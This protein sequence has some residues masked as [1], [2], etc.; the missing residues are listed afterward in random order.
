MSVYKPKDR[1]FFL[2]D[3]QIKGSRFHGSTGAATRGEA[4]RVEELERRKARREIAGQPRQAPTITLDRAA[5]L[6]WS[7]VAKDQRSAKTTDYQLDRL[8]RMLGKST[9]L[10]DI[11]D[12]DI[13][14]YVRVR[15]GQK[16]RNGALPAPATINREIELLR[17]VLYRA[18]KVYKA[19]VPEIDWLAHKLVEPKGR[20]RT[21]SADE[22]R[23]L[24]DAAAP[25][26]RP[27][28]RFSLLTGVRLANAVDLD[29]KQI[30]LQA[31]VIEFR[32]KSNAPDGKPLVMPIGG[33]MLQ[34]LLTLGPKVEGPVFTFKGRKLTTWKTA[35]RRARERAGVK[36]FRWHD[37]RHTFA[38]RMMRAHP[39]LNTLKDLMGHESIA[40]T[41]RYLTADDADRRRALDALD[42]ANRKADSETESRHSPDGKKAAGDK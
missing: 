39:D 38:T 25:H 2:Y 16:G 14:D 42:Q 1:P 7:D 8:A 22:E 34:L 30:D 9:L 17:R 4:R 11:A 28:I 23:R 37:L 19:R 26:L 33:G 40:T 5:G 10:H 12:I 24:I 35:W 13:A 29:W 27:A 32:V 20:T 15:R 36:D 21:L 3:F 31:R 41:T 6:Y 18:K